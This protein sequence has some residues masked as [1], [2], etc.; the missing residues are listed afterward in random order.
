MDKSG[1]KVI[2][3]RPCQLGEGPTY[4]P[5]TGTLYWFDI[6]ERK[7]LE[8]KMPSGELVIH[9][10]PMMA[11]ALAV[12]D[13]ERQLLVTETGLHLRDVATGKLTMH[14]PVEAG[15]ELTR[16][17]DARVHPSG[18]LWFGT[19]AKDEESGLGAGAIYWYRKGELRTLFPDVS[20]PNSICFSPDGAIAY[21]VDS[22][23]N[24][25]H[26]IACDPATGL[27]LGEP[28]IFLD[29]S[30]QDGGIDGSV[31]DAEGVLWNAYWGGGRVDAY[32]PDGKFLRSISVPAK[33]SS[34][35]AFVGKNA[36]HLAVTSAWKGMD[37]AARGG[38]PQGG[39]TFLL[40]VEVKG[41]FE[42]AVVL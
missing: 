4:D 13:P 24:I 35:P 42:P 15:N 2:S 32:A 34:C 3:D 22:R 18:A 7:L 27:P 40:D 8:K 17:N 25:L 16:S 14:L 6:V 28:K 10:L 38:D 23:Q 41:R 31:V 30:G 39:W 12:I 5:A 9:D 20:I 21:Y 11:S 37:A 36:S 19:M 33:Q 1:V 29:R 26:R